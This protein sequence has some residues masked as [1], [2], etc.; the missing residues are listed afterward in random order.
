LVDLLFEKIGQIPLLPE[1]KTLKDL[2]PDRSPRA[3]DLLRSWTRSM[4][5][6]DEVM[7]YVPLAPDFLRTTQLGSAVGELSLRDEALLAT[8]PK[9]VSASRG[10]RRSSRPGHLPKKRK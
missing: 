2:E 4:T 7:R 6:Y 1:F 3:V 8:S 9:V 5:A 10:Q